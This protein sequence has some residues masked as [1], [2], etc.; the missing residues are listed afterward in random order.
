MNSDVLESNAMHI[1]VHDS[2]DLEITLQDSRALH[3]IEQLINSALSWVQKTYPT[4]SRGQ[5]VT[6]KPVK[7]RKRRYTGAVNQSEHSSGGGNSE[8][9]NA[10]REQLNH[11][12][13]RNLDG[14]TWADLKAIEEDLHAGLERV[15]HQKRDLVK[16]WNE[17]DVC[18][19]LRFNETI[20]REYGRIFKAEGIDGEMLFDLT[21]QILKEDFGI[22]KTMHRRRILDEINKLKREIGSSRHPSAGSLGGVSLAASIPHHGVS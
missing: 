6:G 11:L 16:S 5:N 19:W 18:K 3:K 1:D 14:L 13:G 10:M 12:Q 22:K 4:Q 9:L 21:Q 15:R 2:G 20:H 8:Q 7:R 17:D